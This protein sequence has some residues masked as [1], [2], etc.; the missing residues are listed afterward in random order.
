MNNIFCWSEINFFSF[1]MICE[2]K[3]N[4]AESWNFSPSLWNIWW[5]CKEHNAEFYSEL[6]F[7]LTQTNALK[8]YHTVFA[9]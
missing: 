9:K 4:S 5:K 8:K 6:F 2:I 1:D 7:D 3:L